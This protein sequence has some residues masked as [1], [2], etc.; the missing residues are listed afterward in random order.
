[1]IERFEIARLRQIERKKAAP[2]GLCREQAEKVRSFHKSFPQYAATPLVRL[3]QTAEALGLGDIYVKDESA[4]FGLNAFKVLG[5]SYAIACL[6][7]DKACIP[8]SEMSFPRLI[9]PE[10]KRN[11]GE[12]TF[13]TA[14]DG[15]H[16]RGVAWTAA[17]LGMKSVVYMP[18]GSSVER[19]ENIRAEGAHAEISGLNY[20]DTVRLARERA[21][22]NDWVLVQDTSWPGYE[23]VPARIMQGYLTMGLEALE[24]MPQVPTHIFLQAGVG[25]MAG[26][27]TEL[28]A[29]V[30][31]E[32]RPTICLVE[33]EKAN[34]LFRTAR[35][36]DGQLHFVSGDMDTIMAGLAC[37]EPCELA[38][39]VLSKHA[40]YFI[41]CPDY[42]AAKGMRILGNP[43]PDRERV[44]SGESGAAAF[45]CVAEIMTD[46]SLAHI[47]EEL[48][49]NESSRLLFFSTEGATDRENYRSIVW[50]GSFA[51][52]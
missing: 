36:N 24:Q 41:S 10:L 18:K 52:N 9:Q 30:Y 46:P 23:S 32:N 33:P 20:D 5:G 25:A 49:L 48:G 7:A 45:G 31:G 11:L 1:M 13:I 43:Y 44:I 34:C 21:A 4:R 47:K 37:G 16:G 15:N 40:D 39:R 3:S 28:F 14:T 50:S 12:L 35:A 22:E 27:M 29:S 26:A 19:L 6:M 51:G 2:D 8:E 42:A 17:K 38:W